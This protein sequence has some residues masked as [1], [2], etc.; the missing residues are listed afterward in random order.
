MTK[1]DD[2]RQVARTI[3]RELD[4][5]RLAF[6]T[7]HRDRFGTELKARA[8]AGAHS[9]GAVTDAEMEAAFMQ[10]GLLIYPPLADTERDGY[11]RVFRSGTVVAS[12]LNALR[13]PGGGSDSELGSLLWRLRPPRPDAGESQTDG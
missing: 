4:D 1:K 13:F 6:K 8:G 10:E 5:S 12:I 9:K 2:F 3:K 7:Y 11:T